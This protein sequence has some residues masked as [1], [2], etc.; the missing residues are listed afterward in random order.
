MMLRW[1]HSFCCGE[2]RRY[3]SQAAPHVEKFHVLLIRYAPQTRCELLN[4]FQPLEQRHVL[5]VILPAPFRG[6]DGP[7]EDEDL[8]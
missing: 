6:R 4:I 7:G 2:Y 5:E 8:G 1:N 3:S